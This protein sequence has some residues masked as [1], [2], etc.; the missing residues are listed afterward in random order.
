MKAIITIMLKHG[1]LDPQGK[2]IG[3]ALNNLGFTQVGDVRTGKIIEV[4]LAETDPVKAQADVDEM[5]RKLLANMVIESFKVEI[6][7]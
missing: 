2:A 3:Q 5:A 4:E 1:V 6:S 7:A